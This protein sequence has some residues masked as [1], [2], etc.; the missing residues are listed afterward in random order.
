MNKVGLYGGW[1]H[2]RLDRTGFFQGAIKN[3]AGGGRSIQRD[4]PCFSSSG[5]TRLA[6]K[7]EDRTLQ[8]AKKRLIGLR[9]PRDGFE[10]MASI[11]QA[12]GPLQ[13]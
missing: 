5:S 9:E 6:R 11:P 7:T 4:I 12:P 8:Q 1:R 13:M 2:K 10:N 3:P